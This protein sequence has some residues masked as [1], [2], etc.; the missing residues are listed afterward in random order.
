[1]IPRYVGFRALR[2][3]TPNLVG[4]TTPRRL[5]NST[6]RRR[7]HEHGNASL[8]D[9]DLKSSKTPSSSE[10]ESS[11]PEKVRAMMRQIP[12]PLTVI[13]AQSAHSPFPSGLL[14]SSFNT[15]TLSPSPYI[16]FNL[17]LPSSTYSEIQRS[18]T[19]V[20]SAISSV[21]L[22]KDFLLDKKDPRFLSA[23]RDNVHNGDTR[24]RSGRGGIWWTRC[25]YM[26]R[27]SVKV[28]DHVIVVGKV[29]ETGFYDNNP[30]VAENAHSPPLIYSQGKYR[31]AGEA[32]E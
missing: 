5:L 3:L 17:K 30:M 31:V 13:T 25:Q 22:A 29:I 2:P 21:E 7:S 32:I 12:H 8:Q 24:L 6:C 27:E 20:A 19:F 28:A 23:L 16:S 14:V 15:I 10:E 4:T 1:M 11:L 26:E 18:R 9:D